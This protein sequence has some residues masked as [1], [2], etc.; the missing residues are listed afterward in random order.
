[1]YLCFVTKCFLPN[2]NN[3]FV[4][5]PFFSFQLIRPALFVVG[6]KPGAKDCIFKDE[7][8]CCARRLAFNI[9]FF[10]IRA[11]SLKSSFILRITRFLLPSFSSPRR[12]RRKLPSVYERKRENDRFTFFN[13]TDDHIMSVDILNPPFVV[14]YPRFQQPGTLSNV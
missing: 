6:S 13:G 14:Y 3:V 2:I 12:H 11:Q 7:D 5:M 4:W 8:K 1:M 9:Y 10:K